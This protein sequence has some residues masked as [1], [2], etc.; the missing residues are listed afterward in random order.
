MKNSIKK[1]AIM[2]PS[3]FPWMGD[4]YMMDIVDKYVFL[5]DVKLSLSD[6]D[7]RNRIKGSNG[8]IMLT[9]PVKKSL[10]R[11][12]LL[13]KDVF[14][15]NYERVRKKHLTAIQQ[16]Y[17]KSKYYDEIMPVI[18]DIY[19]NKVERLNDFTQSAIKILSIKMGIDVDFIQSS[20]IKGVKSVS[21][22]RLI[23][24]C[25]ILE[26]NMYIS[27]TGSAKYINKNNIGG[28]FNNSEVDLFYRYYQTKEYPQLYGDFINNLSILDL[29]FNVGFSDAINVIRNADIKLLTPIES[30]SLL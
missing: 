20:K 23:S 13:I 1:C 14:I 28:A 4:F 22:K 25:N 24:I 8:E 30:V 2:Q 12:S 26:C 3:F 7:V 15:N 29:L 18:N 10:S 6:W 5:D 19:N 27:P 16:S 11:T 21:D 17:S 9:V